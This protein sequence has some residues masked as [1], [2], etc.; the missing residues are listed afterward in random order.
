MKTGTV[1]AM[2]L[3]FFLMVGGVGCSNQEAKEGEGAVDQVT[4]KAA[5][6]IV[7]RVHT[8]IDRAKAMQSIGDD[9]MEEMD[10]ALN[11]Q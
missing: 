5:K 3:A 10:K 8:P 1:L 7:D 4:T 6:E 9:R 11:N 2:V